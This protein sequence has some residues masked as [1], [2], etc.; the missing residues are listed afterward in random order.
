MDTDHFSAWRRRPGRY[1]PRQFVWISIDD[2]EIQAL[3]SLQCCRSLAAARNADPAPLRPCSAGYAVEVY[4]F[5]WSIE[6]GLM[7]SIRLRMSA[8]GLPSSIL[9]FERADRPCRVSLRI[10]PLEFFWP[11]FFCHFI[12]L[13]VFSICNIGGPIS[14]RGAGRGYL[15]Y[16]CRLVFGPDA[17][18]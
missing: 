17:S 5:A 14:K 8:R 1:S 12:R 13:P 7:F 16:S 2:G 18:R 9:V 10:P 4:P 3:G 15:S 6:R 11:P